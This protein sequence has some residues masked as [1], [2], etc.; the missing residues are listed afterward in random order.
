MK[1]EKL[2]PSEALA[3]YF[4]P[5]R[6]E[7]PL[8]SAP[9]IEKLLAKRAM[10]PNPSHIN[11]RKIIMTLS[12]ITGLGIAAYFAFFSSSRVTDSADRSYMPHPSDLTTSITPPSKSATGAA[13][14]EKHSS[15]PRT[16]LAPRG[17]LER[18]Q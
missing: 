17:P 12:G 4:S 2:Q 16:K 8:L 7:P 14:S 10:L 15:L 13:T 11:V 9:E 18:R 1:N 6:E 3:K 5:R